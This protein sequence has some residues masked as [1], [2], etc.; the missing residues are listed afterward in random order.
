MYAMAMSSV[1]TGNKR[2]GKPQVYRMI[3]AG[4]RIEHAQRC[5]ETFVFL[6]HYIG[7]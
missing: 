5:K 2:R 6:L 3:T 1:Q 4:K 7:D